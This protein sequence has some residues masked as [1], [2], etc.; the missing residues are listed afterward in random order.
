MAG[1]YL[2]LANLCELLVGYVFI[3]ELLLN[4]Y[5]IDLQVLL[6]NC[7]WFLLHAAGVAVM[8]TQI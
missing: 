6:A 5:F 2:A 1:L 4:R 3:E 8:T 7:I